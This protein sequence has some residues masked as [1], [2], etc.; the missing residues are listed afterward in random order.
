MAGRDDGGDN[1]VW[2][3]NEGNEFES[4]EDVRKR[5]S[6]GSDPV[7]TIHTLDFVKSHLEA[8]VESVGGGETFQNIYLVNIDKD[9]LNGFQRLG[10]KREVD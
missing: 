10:T 1:L 3:S 2:L 6:S 5:L 9:V 4:A 8:V 7:H